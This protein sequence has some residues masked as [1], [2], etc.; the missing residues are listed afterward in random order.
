[1]KVLKLVGLKQYLQD[2]SRG[3]VKLNGRLGCYK[4]DP[5]KMQHRWIYKP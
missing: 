4:Y 1:M 2:D 3:C 5:T